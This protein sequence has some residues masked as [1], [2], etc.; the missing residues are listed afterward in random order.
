MTLVRRSTILLAAMALLSALVACGRREEP[1]REG[2]ASAPE[3]EGEGAGGGSAA[4]SGTGGGAAQPPGGA[5][6]GA[7]ATVP[8]TNGGHVAG[9]VRWT[10]P[11]PPMEPLPVT[12]NPEACGGTTTPFPALSIGEGDG[13]QHTF[14]W[15]EGITQGRAFDPVTE[16]NT[17]TIDQASCVYTPHVTGVGVQRPLAFRNSDGVLHNVHAFFGDGQ[18]WFNIAQ[19]TRGMTTRRNAERPGL[20][21]VVCD[22]GHTW[23]VSYVHVMPHPYFATT[24]AAGRFRIEGLPPGQYTI[25][26][27]HEGWRVT[28][29]ASGRPVYSAP[30]VLTQ[31]VTVAAGQDATVSFELS[32]AAAGS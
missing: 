26:A 4:G 11:R 21:R 3:E 7:Y 5:R 12:R 1:R 15:V 2:P 24:D 27:W 18:S 17:P 20:V 19:P 13:V 30:V 28:G 23:M 25:K 22:A 8:V 16:Q 29:N 10:G 6:P 31:Q 14:V 32:T 9:Q